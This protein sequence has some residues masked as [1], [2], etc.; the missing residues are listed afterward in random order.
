MSWS[1]DLEL[2]D[3]D[4]SSVPTIANL[5]SLGSIRPRKRERWRSHVLGLC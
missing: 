2:P 1:E 5:S 4:W 3:S